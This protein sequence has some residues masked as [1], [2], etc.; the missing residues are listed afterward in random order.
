MTT[1]YVFVEDTDTSGGTIHVWHSASL[2]V[3]DGTMQNPIENTTLNII[4]PQTLNDLQTLFS[5]PFIPTELKIVFSDSAT[6]GSFTSL[7]SISVAGE[8]F[9]PTISVYDAVNFTSDAAVI[10]LD[11]GISTL[12]WEFECN[13]NSG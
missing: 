7:N 12:P 5:L 10:T 1:L 9:N 4:S 3:E 13:F 11:P 8:S 6:D 2:N